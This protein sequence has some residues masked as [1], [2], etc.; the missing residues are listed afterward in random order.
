MNELST[1]SWILISTAIIDTSVAIA[2]LA[3]GIATLA[4]KIATWLFPRVRNQPDLDPRKMLR[5]YRTTTTVILRSTSGTPTFQQLVDGISLKPK[6]RG[7]AE[8]LYETGLEQFNHPV[9]NRDGTIIEARQQI[10][11]ISRELNQAERTA[12]EQVGIM[13]ASAKDKE[14]KTNAELQYN[15]L[16]PNAKTPAQHKRREVE[17]QKTITRDLK[18][19]V[20][21][22]DYTAVKQRIASGP[23]DLASTMTE[24]P[25][26]WQSIRTLNEKI[27]RPKYN[28]KPTKPEW[29]HVEFHMVDGRMLEDKHAEKDG[30]WI[31]SHKHRFLVPC[32]TPTRILEFNDQGKAVPTGKSVLI[33][34]QD[35]SSEWETKFWCQGGYMD[36]TYLKARAGTLPYQLRRAHRQRQ[37]RKI[38]WCLAGTSIVAYIVISAINNT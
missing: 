38:Q 15:A 1:T 11:N 23:V 31:L 27:D 28:G 2:M 20:Q 30:D 29:V 6:Q 5:P 24:L 7:L 36:Q 26:S 34:D 14:E 13:L 19:N 4:V 3:V 32:P 25:I 8:K 17:A 9:N 21:R 18:C 35:P 33:V 37:I 12:A 10:T 22:T 16:P